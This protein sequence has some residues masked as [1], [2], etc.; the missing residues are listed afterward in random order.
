MTK[1]DLRKYAPCMFIM[2]VLLVS[3]CISGESSQQGTGTTTYQVSIHDNQQFSSYEELSVEL[4]PQNEVY[5]FTPSNMDSFLLTSRQKEF[6]EQYGFVVVPSFEDKL[7]HE[8]YDT[9]RDNNIP[10][11]VTTDSILN[12]FHILYDYSLRC[13]EQDFFI[14][15]LTLLTLSMCEASNFQYENSVGDV[16]EAAK[17]NVAF[18][19]IALKLLDQEAEVPNYV[20]DIVNAELALIDGSNGIS[21]SPLFDYREDYSQY[22]PR[23]H[24]TRTEELGHYFKA[25]MWYGRMPFRLKEQLET[26]AAILS[27]LAIQNITIEDDNAVLIWD[28]IYETTSFFVGEADDLTLHDYS[29]LIINI[30]GEEVSLDDVDDSSLLDEFIDQAK[31]LRDPKINSSVITDQ[32]DLV[33]DTKGFRFMGQRFILDSYIFSQLVYDNVTSYLGEDTPFTLVISDAGPIRGFPRGLDV[34][35]VL[36]FD[37]AEQILEEEGDAEYIDY[38]KQI[39]ALRK[40]VDAYTVDDW[41][42]NMYTS[43]LYCLSSYQTEPTNGWPAFMK[44]QM[45]KRKELFTALGSW[46]QLRHDTILYAKQSYTFEATSVP[47]Q[48]NATNGYVE[49]NAVLYARLLSLT[50][51][52][53]NGLMER[54]LITGEFT[55][56]FYMYDSLLQA[57]ITISEKEISGQKIDGAEYE[58]IMNIGTLLEDITTFSKSVQDSIVS[59]ADNS[60]ALV[61]DVH[62]DVNSMMVLEEAVGYPFTLFVIVNVEGETY[63]SQGPVFSYY[64]FK[65]PL[66]DR[67][68]DE[69]WQEILK[70]G[71]MPSIPEWAQDFVVN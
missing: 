16:R 56:K 37:E 68:T 1:K 70:S 4:N 36:N 41:A 7:F 3:A 9:L 40:E 55:E 39:E 42:K 66:D 59:E 5:E 49:P 11:F 31:E 10:I 35:S 38:D 57:L 6:L 19:T 52:A 48:P 21:I 23:G 62:T 8:Y 34:F 17:M 46:T 32:Q 25:M 60:L 13:I 51:M 15:D 14:N 27:V 12:S 2:I 22:V 18:F 47:Q 24:Y 58:L 61:A 33:D 26:R 67:L 28:N 29:Q 71:D 65:H 63:I 30:Y 54:G 44:S 45:W 64:E 20:Q 43:W 69:K 50:R 53:H